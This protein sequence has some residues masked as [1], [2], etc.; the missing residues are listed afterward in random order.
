M[1]P[2]HG[3]PR[4]NQRPPQGPP[5]MR[6][7]GP[8]GPGGP[9]PH[10]MPRPNYPPPG[11]RPMTPPPPGTVPVKSQLPPRPPV[12]EGFQPE[13]YNPEVPLIRGPNS[14]G[15]WP[16]PEK[17]GASGPGPQHNAPFAG[18]GPPSQHGRGAL[19]SIP[20]VE[21]GNRGMQLEVRSSENSNRTVIASNPQ[22]DRPHFQHGRKH[23]FDYSR[24]GGKK[25]NFDPT[26]TTL[27][28]RKV[29]REL[30]NIAKLNEHFSKFGNIV[31]LQISYGGDPE[32]A[33]VTFQTR[34]Q[35]MACYRNP[36]PV[37]NNRFIKLF[38]HNKDKGEERPEA[39][40]SSGDMAPHKPSVKER[41]GI[42]PAHKMQLNNTAKNKAAAALES[43]DKSLVVTNPKGGL[44]KTVF[45][46]AAL[47]A[48]KSGQPVV[49]RLGAKPVVNRKPDQK[50]EVFR[51][52]L[53]IQKQKQILLEKQLEQ[54]KILLKKIED[55]K[56]MSAEDKATVIKTIKLLAG[57]I[58][59]LEKELKSS[60]S[61][62]K[63]A[64]PVVKIQ[65]PPETPT[66]EEPQPKTQLSPGSRTKQQA[67]KEILDAELE[68]MNKQNAGVDT[69]SLR[70]KVAELKREATSLGLLGRRGRGRFGPFARNRGRG[71][72]RGG[73]IMGPTLSVDH[74]PRTLEITGFGVE[75]TEE[76]VQY[77]S[78][79]GELESSSCDESVPSLSIAFK[80]RQQA[81][82]AAVKSA[83]FPG[84]PLTI[85]WKRSNPTS[86]NEEKK[87]IQAEDKES[88]SL[89]QENFEDAEES[90]KTV[91]EVLDEV[92]D[93]EDVLEVP[94]NQEEEEEEK[95]VGIHVHHEV[96]DVEDVDEDVLLGI[97]EEE[98]EDDE[99]RSWRR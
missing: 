44:T 33:L 34:P 76:V 18:Q 22:N 86:S 46:P 82:Q 10:H 17:T 43:A 74:R 35:A 99:S 93:E 40:T 29:P 56:N 77:F 42:P 80:T 92:E 21:D 87:D 24:L 72:G 39:D 89:D 78:Q 45:N 27:E 26:N 62:V 83:S 61:A 20:T 57:S 60:A 79:H 66:G 12:S 47:S 51:K 6:G 9:P 85:S 30:N 52:N 23:G 4:M 5:P 65:S 2:M 71:R 38:W 96:D 41:L 1:R 16:S 31:N 36:E 58:D 98:D 11:P 97:D 88:E 28:L 73:R 25:S 37:F 8:L 63:P 3:P 70:A 64:K 95:P 84:A 13:P 50:K 32:A 53:E 54:Q 55:N 7:P 15:Y 91:A 68:L 75:Q 48:A 69:S 49:A 81:E 14:G 90:S 67:Q 19:V 94:G 59:R